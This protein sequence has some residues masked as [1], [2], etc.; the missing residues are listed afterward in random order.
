MTSKS[1]RKPPGKDDPRK[2]ST[3]GYAEEQLHPKERGRKL[4]GEG[5]PHEPHNNPKQKPGRGNG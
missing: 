2:Q 1:P 4:P 3:T 5:A